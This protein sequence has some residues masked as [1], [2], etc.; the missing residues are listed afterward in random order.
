MLSGILDLVEFGAFSS[1]LHMVYFRYFIHTLN[2]F[3]DAN[4]SSFT[5]FG[6]FVMHGRRKD[7]SCKKIVFSKWLLFAVRD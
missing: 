6:I 5:S 1:L 3:G 4:Y 2:G 7:E